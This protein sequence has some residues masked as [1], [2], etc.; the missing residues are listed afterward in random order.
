MIKVKICGITN[1][2]DAQAAV[3]YNAD[4]V[5]F[6][7]YKKSKRCISPTDAKEII[8]KLPPFITKVGVFVDEDE[9]FI[10]SVINATGINAVQLHGKEPPYFCQ[11]WHTVI[12]AVRI[13]DSR[14][15]K[16]I[17]KHKP[18]AFLLDTFTKDEAGGTGIVFNW[19]IA[20]TAVSMGH[21][22][23]LAGGLTADNVQAA[24]KMVMP[25]GVDVSS[26]IE[27]SYGIK[28]HGKMKLF[29]EEAKK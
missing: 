3:V 22:I 18:S 4:A 12:K 23:I 27:A 28:D 16:E 10:T 24:V 11:K 7:F 14:D 13:K 9:D 25:Y 6:V 20:K 29:I 2:K 1:L 19:D 5:G 15:L 8:T 17:D 26:G 21:R